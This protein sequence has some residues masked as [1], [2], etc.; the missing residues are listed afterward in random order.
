[1][2]IAAILHDNVQ[3]GAHVVSVRCGEASFHQA[4]AFYGWRIKNANQ[5]E[6]MARVVQGGVI[7]Q[8]Q[9]LS[10]SSPS[11]KIARRSIYPGLYARQ[12]LDGADHVSAAADRGGGS[13]HFG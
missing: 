5:S 11:H 7:Q 2:L 3:Y 12:H 4:G 10:G 8:D 1:L 13:D 6:Y 9:V